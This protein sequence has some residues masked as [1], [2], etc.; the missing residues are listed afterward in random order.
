MTRMASLIAGVKAVASGSLIGT[1]LLT[2]VALIGGLTMLSNGGESVSSGLL[3]ILLPFLIGA[4][5]AAIGLVVIGLPL[6][7]W[8]RRRRSESAA[9]YTLVGA[10][11]GG[12]LPALWGLALTQL[13]IFSIVLGFFG[14]LTGT[15]TGY[16]WWRFAR[17]P[18]V[19]GA[20]EEV[21]EVFG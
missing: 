19:E 7:W 5:G 2:A 17:K 1:S 13:G 4:A 10:L 12:G 14:M 9:A 16:F 6:T 15:A 11:A 3:V 21:A 20:G 18:V 8:L